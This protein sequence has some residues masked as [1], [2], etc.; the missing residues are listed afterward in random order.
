MVQ[1]L[2]PTGGSSGGGPGAS[3]LN[4]PGSSV[5]PPPFG[6]SSAGHSSHRGSTVVSLLIF[7]DSLEIL[8]RWGNVSLALSRKRLGIV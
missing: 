8:F 3:G 2:L 4:S 1:G 7:C 6:H 5:Q